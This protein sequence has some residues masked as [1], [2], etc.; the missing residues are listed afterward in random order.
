MMEDLEVSDDF[1]SPEGE[2][3]DRDRAVSGGSG[4]CQS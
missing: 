4:G 1:G 2:E 3:G